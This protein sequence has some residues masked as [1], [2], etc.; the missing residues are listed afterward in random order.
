MRVALFAATP[1]QVF[2][3]INLCYN[4][5]KEDECDIFLLDFALDMKSLYKSLN[6]NGFFKNVYLVDGIAKT[7][8]KIGVI[9]DFIFTD[10][11]FSTVLNNKFYDI[12]YLTYLGDRNDLI[13]NLVLKNNCNVSLYFYDEGIG[14][15]VT[16]FYKSSQNMIR[17]YK[18]LRNRYS[19]DC[20]KKVFVYQPELVFS[21]INCEIVKIPI[22]NKYDKGIREVYNEIFEFVKVD[23]YESYIYIYM[24]QCFSKYMTDDEYTDLFK[25]DKNNISKEIIPENKKYNLL[26][27]KHPL[28]PENE[29]FTCDNY[30]FAKDYTTPWEMISMN[31]DM[32]NKVLITINSTA[33]LT[34]KM[35]Y[36]EEPCIILLGKAIKN[37]G[38]SDL[39]WNDNLDKLIEKL[40][41][42]Y[43]DKNKIIVP[44]NIESFEHLL[45]NI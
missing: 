35:I 18:F 6:S 38:L 15:Y 30:N 4:F 2:N 31:Y 22:I 3:C 9:K 14:I 29:Y 25:F 7:P 23:K 1:Y 21:N 44:D 36:D 32:S 24:D 40:R 33:A 19:V 45:D 37:A 5:H 16:G 11:Q 12:L 43:S 27:K 20:F 13:Y 17:M 10:K 34:P 39:V 26:I 42:I 41:M 8:G 28:T